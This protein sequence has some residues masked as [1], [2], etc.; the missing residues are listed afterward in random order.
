M[1]LLWM[2]AGSV[3]L[4]L[5]IVLAPRRRRVAIKRMLFGKAI[6]DWL[7]SFSEVPRQLDK[8][9]AVPPPPKGWDTLRE[10]RDA[11][12][13][14]ERARELIEDDA[15]YQRQFEKQQAEMA[16]QVINFRTRG[17]YLEHHDELIELAKQP[18][19]MSDA[20]KNWVAE[21]VN[22]N[23]VAKA[24]LLLDRARKGD[25]QSFIELM[26]FAPE[27]SASS[28]LNWLD[29]Y[30]G[31][32][33]KPYEAPKD[34]N[35]LVVRY[36]ENP[37]LDDFRNISA[38]RL[39]PGDCRLMAASALQE[40]SLV[41]GQIVLALCKIGN[42]DSSYR[43]STSFPWRDE[44]GAVLLADVTKMVRRLQKQEQVAFSHTTTE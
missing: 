6:N 15:R 34:W 28:G 44:I 20:D 29:F 30:S 23:A 36:F 1:Y 33:G 37:S 26:T 3:I 7:A 27:Y 32:T 8:L 39:T 38:N 17:D 4:L 2:I 16:T 24:D 14:I 22:A 10:V 12:A 9:A 41:L 19:L 25:R 11:Q 31:Q 21:Q 43:P 35:K 13:A 5:V 18:H 40:E 42:N